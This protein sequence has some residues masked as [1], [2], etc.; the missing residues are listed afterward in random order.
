MLLL[1][2]CALIF[3]GLSV[4]CWCKAT[5]CACHHAEECNNAIT[6]Y[7]LGC[8]ALAMCS[9]MFCYLALHSNKGT[10]LWLVL[11]TSCLIGATLCRKLSK[12]KR[13]DA[14][15]LGGDLLT[16]EIS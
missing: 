4:Y 8:I 7:W 12:R 6:L 15:K 13:C 5:Y 2:L 16:N 1:I 3:S 11:T 9:L 10:M 14:T